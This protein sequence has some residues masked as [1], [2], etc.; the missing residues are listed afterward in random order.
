MRSFILGL[1]LF[2]LFSLAQNS[3]FWNNYSIT[4]PAATGLNARHYGFATYSFNIDPYFK[5]WDLAAGY[6][7]KLASLHG[8]LGLNVTSGR[9]AWFGSNL[10]NLNYSYHQNIGENNILAFGVAAGMLNIFN[11]EL[12]T[13]YEARSE[14]QFNLNLGTIFKGK[15]IELGISCTQLNQPSFGDSIK[16]RIGPNLVFYGQYDFRLSNK[17]NLIPRFQ[18]SNN[19]GFSSIKLNT[20]F[21]FK[22]QYWCGIGYFHRN[23]FSLMAGVDLFEKFR[24]GYSLELPFHS[25]SQNR[26]THSFAIA[27]M[28][29]GD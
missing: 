14:T 26:M 25:I 17:F 2:P 20:T 18:F 9:F 5:S 28:L 8:G 11:E 15:N 4:N 22:K 10:A 6:D 27:I 19:N 29:G 1:L 12:D 24:M 23:T 16:F 3:F 7:A 13:I 21:L